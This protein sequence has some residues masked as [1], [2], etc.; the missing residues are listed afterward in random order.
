MLLI[1]MPLEGNNANL[2]TDDLPVGSFSVIEPKNFDGTQI[3]QVFITAA[4]PSVV[5]A[6]CTY[7]VTRA[8]DR[9]SI[10]IKFTSG[11]VDAEIQGKLNDKKLQ[12]SELYR[13][14]V[15]LITAKAEGEEDDE[16]DD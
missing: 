11:L 6:I 1:E 16:P 5:T 4:V 14:L 9:S 10:K 12:D 7:L 13:I 15:Q 3:I 8:Q 2:L